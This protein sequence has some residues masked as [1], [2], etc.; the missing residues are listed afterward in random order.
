VWIVVPPSL[1]DK[2]R[3]GG[4]ALHERLL[5]G[6]WSESAGGESCTLLAEQSTLLES[7]SSQQAA[8]DRL[9]LTPA[10]TAN[11]RHAALQHRADRRGGLHA[12]RLF[13]SAGPQGLKARALQPVHPVH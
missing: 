6:E 4:S 10:S 1:R 3:V 9:P 12:R 8:C 11:L 7:A 5:Q 2:L 13:G